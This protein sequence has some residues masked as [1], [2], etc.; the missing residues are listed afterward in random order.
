MPH[1]PSGLPRGVSRPIHLTHAVFA[2]FG[3]DG[4]RAECS[5]GWRGMA[6]GLVALVLW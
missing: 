2:D 6:M 4:I 1:T 3:G 5:A